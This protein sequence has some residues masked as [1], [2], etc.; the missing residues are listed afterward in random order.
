MIDAL[1]HKFG[2]VR[3]NIE[4]L[5]VATPATYIRYTNN[6]TGG[7]ISW[8]ATKKTFGKPTT[9]S[10]KGLDNFYMT[11]QWAGTSGGLVECGYDG[12][13]SDTDHL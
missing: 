13:S 11:G 2:N 12:K 9:W 10:I 7:Q 8:K 6:W 5:D 1:E 3:D 4:M